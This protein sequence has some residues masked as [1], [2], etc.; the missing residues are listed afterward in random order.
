VRAGFLHLSTSS[1]TTAATAEEAQK[2]VKGMEENTIHSKYI[3]LVGPRAYASV[4]FDFTTTVRRTQTNGE[5]S[6]QRKAKARK[7]QGCRYVVLHV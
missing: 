3:E 7:R 4:Q 1:L 6:C 5:R 2:S